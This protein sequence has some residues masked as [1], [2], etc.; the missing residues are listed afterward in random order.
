MNFLGRRS[1]LTEVLDNR[2]DFKF[3]QVAN[4]SHPPLLKV[5]YISIQ[6][7]PHAFHTHNVI[8]LDQMTTDNDFNSINLPEAYLADNFSDHTS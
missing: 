3:L 1:F 5:L 4:V 6:A 8:Q 2:P 7:R